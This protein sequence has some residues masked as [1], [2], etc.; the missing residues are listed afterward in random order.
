MPDHA[1]DVAT[2]VLPIKA[3]GM[4]GVVVTS[5]DNHVFAVAICRLIWSQRL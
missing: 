1:V 2:E 4:F 3:L 5:P